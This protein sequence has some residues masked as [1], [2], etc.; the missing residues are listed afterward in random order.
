MDQPI[1]Q[2]TTAP[3]PVPPA[4]TVPAMPAVFDPQAMMNLIQ[5]LLMQQQEVLMEKQEKA[6]AQ[7]ARDDARRV[8]AEY[9]EADVKKSQ[10]LCTHKKGGKRG[11]K[12][13]K[14]DY[15]VYFHTF[16][17]NSSYI[18]CQI[19]GMKWKE[20][21]TDEYLVRRGE[22]IKNHT[23]IG[24]KK[25]FEMLGQSTNSPSSSE[26]MVGVQQLPQEMKDFKNPHTVEV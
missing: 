15:A 23:G 4:S 3:G 13:T 20:K 6:R 14:L 7:K 16:V 26:V 10:E 17:D 11:P 12:S 19:C 25:A 22:K 2:S 5:L 21:D 9:N 24:W 18:R 8:A 1:K